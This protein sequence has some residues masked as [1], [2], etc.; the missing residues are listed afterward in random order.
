M[1]IKL[2]LIGGIA[3]T[4]ALAVIGVQ[5]ASAK[6]Y[7]LIMSSSHPPIVPWVKVL[8]ELVVPEANKRLKARGSK[9]TIKWTEAYAGSLYNFQNTLEGI[10]QGLGDIG[11]IGTLWEPVKMPLHNVAYYA[12][13][14]AT[15]AMDLMEIQIDL[16]ANFPAFGKEWT[17]RNI[18]L[19]SQ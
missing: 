9:H 2:L 10:E 15:N 3:A 8:K 11:W 14:A 19:D 7:K 12:T 17:R 1:K 6:E 13:F 16:E 18:R 5:S 4:A